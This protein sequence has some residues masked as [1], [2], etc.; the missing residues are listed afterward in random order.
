MYKELTGRFSLG[1]A[2]LTVGLFGPSARANLIQDGG[3]ETPVVGPG[4][5]QSGFQTFVVGQMFGTGNPWTEV[6]S[7]S[8]NVAVYP[9]TKTIG[10]QPPALNVQKGSQALDLTG[11]TDNGAATGVSQSFATTVDS[12]YSL[13]FYVGDL[14]NQVA[15][16]Y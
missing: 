11:N 8:G 12:I 2:L 3:F 7:S 6:G 5:F 4:G 13:S 16:K 10:S 15:S 1:L 14:N 9:N